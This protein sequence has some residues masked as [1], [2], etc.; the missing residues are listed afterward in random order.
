MLYGTI[1]EFCTEVS[2]PVMSAG[3]KYEVG[4][5]LA[6]KFHNKYRYRY[7]YRNTGTWLVRGYSFVYPIKRKIFWICTIITF[8]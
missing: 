1:T 4:G 5:L 8:T 7:R 2:C 3:P 6:I